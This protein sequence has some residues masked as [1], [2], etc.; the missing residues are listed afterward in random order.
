[1][2]QALAGDM[3]TALPPPRLFAGL[4]RQTISA[5]LARVPRRRF[6]AEQYLCRQ[7][8]AGDSLYLIMEGLVEIWLEQVHERSLI[9]R[10]W[11]GD[12]VGEMSLLTGEP[13]AASVM[14]AVPTEILE[15]DARTFAGVLAEHPVVL[16]NVALMLI[17]RQ[18][19]ANEQIL[20]RQERGEALALVMGERT[21]D[22]AD[23]GIAAAEH[24]SPREVAVIDMTGKL[25]RL[26]HVV[27]A[28]RAADVLGA[29]DLMLREQRIVIVTAGCR[30]PDLP[31][32]L[33][34]L[35]RA[36]YLLSEAEAHRLKGCIEAAHAT[37][38][39]ILID[40]PLGRVLGGRA[41]LRTISLPANERDQRWLGRHLARTKL[42]LALGAGGAKSYAHIGAL[43]VLE[44]AGYEV[45]YVSG[46]SFGAIV[47]SCIA[48]GMDASQVR[49]KL[50]HLLSLEVC[51]SYFRLVTEA[52]VDGEQVFD[53]ALSEL[54]GERGF[55]DLPLPLG[56]LTADLNAQ[57]PHAFVEGRLAEALSAAL[58]I[59]GLAP[60]YQVG[61]CRLIDGVTISPVPVRLARQL[62]AD[63]T[64]A[65][66]LMSRDHLE[67]WP[68]ASQPGP[69]PEKKPHHLDPVVE[70]II[71]L[72]TDTSVRN[73]D[74]A[75][76]PITPRFGPSSWRD[77]HLAQLFEAAGREAALGQLDR[78]RSLARPPFA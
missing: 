20:L 50:D 61:N 13:R 37:T 30:Q 29:L 43:E 14:A 54:A 74:E 68:S 63:I 26:C 7:G 55:G 21:A 75:D 76:L 62:G 28:E 18:K 44:G 35:D 34:A 57:L 24:A 38:E 47:G 67:A 52:K 9:T 69:A 16:R 48:M 19:L 8:D 58:A 15:L 23:Q 56:I 40:S 49:R 45:D 60:P 53:R 2:P 5:I 33:R 46:A 65:V 59:P 10:L 36:V 39:W 73:A 32:L 27:A 72:Q 1:M 12:A 31:V 3:S 41:P 71:M 78:L 51:G 42:G 66:N 17:E 77:I 11:P 64:V 25:R 70:T 22:L 4:D 6:D